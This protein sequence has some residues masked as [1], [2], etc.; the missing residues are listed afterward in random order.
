MESRTPLIGNAPSLPA[1]VLDSSERWL[2]MNVICD[3]VQGERL[4]SP[5]ITT[6]LQLSLPCLNM[7]NRLRQKQHYSDRNAVGSKRETSLGIIV[8][9]CPPF[10]IIPLHN[11]SASHPRLCLS[12]R[13][14]RL[15]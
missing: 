10:A 3:Y 5:A 8:S 13:A 1:L 12:E 9:S 14:T 6:A 11:F 15:P 7:N 2:K 4:L